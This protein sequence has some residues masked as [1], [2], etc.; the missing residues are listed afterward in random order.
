MG[1]GKNIACR[2]LIPY[3]ILTERTVPSY[4]ILYVCVVQGFFNWLAQKAGLRYM[5]M[6]HIWEVQDP[7]LV[8]VKEPPKVRGGHTVDVM[9]ERVTYV[10]I[11][12]SKIY[13]IKKI[14]FV[15]LKRK[16]RA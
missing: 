5:D 9:P 3:V 14:K 2:N 10:S 4:F 8:E 11:L 6:D 13:F 7:L 1:A 16:K 12:F 15:V